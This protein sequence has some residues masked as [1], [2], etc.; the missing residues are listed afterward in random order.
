MKRTFV[1]SLLRCCMVKSTH[2]RSF[3]LTVWVYRVRNC[4]RILQAAEKGHTESYIIC[5]AGVVGPSRGPVPA[6]SIFFKFMAQL[7]LA[8]K[9]ALYVGEGE[10][11]FYTVGTPLPPYDAFTVSLT[12]LVALG[13]SG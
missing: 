7:A 8:F 13:P 4:R 6:N 5:P 2:R 1:L 12:Q 11:V 10:N 3:F 9:K